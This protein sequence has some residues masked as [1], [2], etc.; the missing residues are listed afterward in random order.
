MKTVLHPRIASSIALTVL[1]MAPAIA[2][3]VGP[4]PTSFMKW[5]TIELPASTGA[6]CSNGTPYRFFVNRSTNAT[7]KNNTV[8]MFEGGGA[9]WD[10]TSCQGFLK[11]GLLAAANTNGIPT[12]YMSGLSGLSFFGWVTPFTSRNHPLQKVQTQ[13]WNIVYVPYCTGDVHTGNKPA[14]YSDV[15]AKKPLT[16]L[17]K[18]A[19]NGEAIA[20]WLGK[21]MGKPDKLLVTGFSAGGTGATAN[22]GWIRLAM[23]PKQSALLADSGPLFPAPRGGSLADY[24]SLPLQNKVR[25]AW[26]VDGPDG[27]ATK[28]I[29]RYPEAGTLDDLGSISPGLAKVFPQDRLGYAAF[30]S[31]GIYSD[32]SYSKFYPE[33]AAASGAAKQALLLQKWRKDT[34]NW[35]NGFQGHANIGYYL[36]WERNFL[37]SHTLTTGSFANTGIREANIKDVGAFVDNLLDA[38]APL[39]RVVESPQN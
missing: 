12:N 38:S 20:N 9:C 14:I 3:E 26:G 4:A 6:A 21:Y 28:L 34:Q 36:P 19:V 2:A 10:Q 17:H 27:I 33:I 13:S 7:N 30:Q 23:Q 32:F 22:Y 25:S 35:V 31:D 8:V 39:I 24:P 16:Y 1:A 29:Q 11:G 15:D 18:G 5:E 37:L